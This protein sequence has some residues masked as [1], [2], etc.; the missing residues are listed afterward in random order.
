[1]SRQPGDSLEERLQRAPHEL[2]VLPVL[3]QDGEEHRQPDVA[4]GKLRLRGARHQQ[5]QLDERPP[6]VLVAQAAVQT[7]EQRLHARVIHLVITLPCSKEPARALQP[8]L[9][10]VGHAQEPP[11]PGASLHAARTAG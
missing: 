8:S 1:M 4:A 5:L 3:A 2:Q 7:L 6:P 11:C 9:E 10:K